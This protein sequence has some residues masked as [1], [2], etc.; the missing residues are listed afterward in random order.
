MFIVREYAACLLVPLFAAVVLFAACGVF[1][2]V[3][4]GYRVGTRLLR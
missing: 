4:A 3:K 1:V 2:A